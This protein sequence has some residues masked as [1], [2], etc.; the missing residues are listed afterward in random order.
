MLQEH[1]QKPNH[2]VSHRLAFLDAEYPQHTSYNLVVELFLI[3]ILL[4]LC[5]TVFAAPLARVWW[6]VATCFLNLPQIDDE[7]A[8]RGSSLLCIAEN[9][10]YLCA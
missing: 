8:L 1:A 5:F 9:L 4:H 6:L 3:E 7:F 2:S 10:C